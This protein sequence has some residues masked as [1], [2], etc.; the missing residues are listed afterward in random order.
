MKSTTTTLI[1][2]VILCWIDFTSVAE[3]SETLATDKVSGSRSESI[4]APA[5]QLEDF[6]GKKWESNYTQSRLTV[7]FFFGIE[8]PLAKTYI[9][10]M[11]EI[12]SEYG[13]GESTETEKQHPADLHDSIAWYGINSNPQ[14]SLTE[15]AG[16]ASRQ[17]ITFPLLKDPDGRLAASLG[18]QR[19]PEV[20][21]IDRKGFIR[22]RGK[23]DD[24]YG[25]GYSRPQATKNY[26]S[27]TLQ[28]L[29]NDTD[30]FL[31]TTKTEAV[32]CRLGKTPSQENS[33]N[34][35]EASHSLSYGETISGILNKHCTSCHRE[36]Q[37]GP[38][39]LDNFE[40]ASAWID[41]ICEVVED[42]RMPPW[43]ANP[44]V[45]H[46]SNDR[47][48]S[49][50]EIQAIVAWRAAGTPRGKQ[51]VT[52]EEAPAYEGWQLAR[53]PDLIV[54]MSD[55]PFQVPATGVVDYKYFKVDPH[56]DEDKWVHAYEIRPGNRSVVHHVLIF[57]VEE[58]NEQ[59][60]DAERS[61]LAGYVPGTRVLPY[62]KGMAKK[63][64]KGS[65]LIFQVH[66][67]PV[68]TAQEDLSEVGFLFEDSAAITHEVKT[69][70]AVQSKLAIPPGSSDYQAKARIKI[71]EPDAEL[72][73]MSP[74]MHVRGKSFSYELIHPDK[75][76]EPLLDIPAYD[77]GWQTFYALS[78]PKK[79]PLGGHI[80]CYATF[81]NSEANLNN[82]DPKKLVTWGDQTTDEMMIGY[83]DYS[84]PIAKP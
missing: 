72:L 52:P 47:S 80:Q 73:G 64:P 65:K 54:R 60:I 23:I 56:F 16:L 63:I 50:E 30:A 81:D 53:K 18:V 35:V 28:I 78:Q 46:F 20:F 4:L 76:R 70:S 74:H 2:L 83:F 77:F 79:L 6:R 24:R 71:T 21:V 25:I 59:K 42:R 84:K 26:L 5:W 27:E 55:K 58:G 38:M 49:D 1:L 61:Y 14:D 17:S 12:A 40:D 19:V 43:H 66:Y 8:C 82:P 9:N 32:G 15:I 34:A 51:I 3:A 22:Y 39:R 62:P 57:A 45:G 67:T 33:L 68:G 41:M 44:K 37:I 29:S 48:L 36:G 75:R 13:S 7:L 10:R 31:A 69:Y 11:Q